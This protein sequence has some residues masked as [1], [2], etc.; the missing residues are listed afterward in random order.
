M[1]LAQDNNF[2]KVERR[3]IQL[4]FSPGNFGCALIVTNYNVRFWVVVH[5]SGEKE[6]GVKEN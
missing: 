3:T 2:D 4:G 6:M 1:S 5:G